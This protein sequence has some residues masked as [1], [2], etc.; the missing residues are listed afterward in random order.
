MEKI[1]LLYRVSSK[2]QETDGSS[3]DVQKEI[4]IKISKILGLKY[5]EFDE[6][7]QSS[8]KVEINQRP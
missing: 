5:Q 8:F 1:G 2:P 3:L 6:G 4:G 7:V